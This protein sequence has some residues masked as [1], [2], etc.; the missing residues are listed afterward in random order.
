[1]N[2]IIA[3]YYIGKRNINVYACYEDDEKTIEF[4]DIYEDDGNIQHHLNLGSPFYDD[5]DGVPSY[6]VIED[7]INS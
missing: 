1:M 3:T 5:G 7:F 6:E 4:F 2:K